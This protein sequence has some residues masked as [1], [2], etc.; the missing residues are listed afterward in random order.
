MGCSTMHVHFMSGPTALASLGA[1]LYG[2]VS[3]SAS[4]HSM[5]ENKTTD[6]S[7]RRWDQDGLKQRTDGKTI[8]ETA[9]G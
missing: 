6:Y 5:L 7:Q 2:F 1:L 3:L 4:I 9:A 8:M